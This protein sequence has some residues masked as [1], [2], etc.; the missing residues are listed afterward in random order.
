METHAILDLLANPTPWHS[1]TEMLS[2]MACDYLIAGTGYWQR[3][4]PTATGPPK[5]LWWRPESSIT[6]KLNDERSGLAGFEYKVEG[7]IMQ[8]APED[9]VQVRNVVHGQKPCKSL[10]GRIAADGVGPGGLDQSGSDQNDG[11]AA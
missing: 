9:V 2:A 11:G 7:K 4:G 10:A 1:G 6:P 5:E 3:V 8:W